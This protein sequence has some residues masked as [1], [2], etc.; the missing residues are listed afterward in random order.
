MGWGWGG[1]PSVVWDGGQLGVQVHAD[2]FVEAAEGDHG[3]VAKVVE[4]VQV[5]P[6]FRIPQQFVPG[7][8]TQFSG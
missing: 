1:A 5:L 8:G 2:V 4:A 7:R 3:A 6:L